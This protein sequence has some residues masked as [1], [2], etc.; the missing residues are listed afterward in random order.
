[1]TKYKSLE[2][3]KENI[4]PDAVYQ[5]MYQEMRRYR[6]YEITS[7]QWYTGFLVII[8]GAMINAKQ[9]NPLIL[10]CV[11]VL[12]ILLTFCGITSVIYAKTRHQA[13]RKWVTDWYEP[14]WKDFKPDE[15]GI[16][17]WKLIIVSQIALCLVN[18]SIAKILIISQC[19]L[20][21]AW[22]WGW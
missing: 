21:P 8:L 13:L 22:W 16:K 17:P 4:S 2:D 20:S 10:F 19:H 3:A 5:E 6:D 14:F 11:I 9:L 1:M 7:S 15:K 18:I 12:S